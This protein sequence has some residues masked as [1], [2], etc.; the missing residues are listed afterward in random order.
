M[1]IDKNQLIV[2]HRGRVSRE[3]RYYAVR[4][5]QGENMPLVILVNNNSASATEIVAGAVQDHDRG[6][7]V[8]ERTFGKGLVQ[9]VEPLSENTGLALTVARYYTPSG[10]LIQRDYKS[11]SLYSYHYERKVPEH[12]TEV[13]LTDSGRLVTGG[14][15]ITPDITVREPEYTPFQKALLRA[16][17][18]YPFETSVGGFTLHYLGTRPTITK[19]FVVDDAVMTDFRKFLTTKNVHYSEP[20]L[21]EN[22]DWV[23]RKTKQ[24][25][26]LSVFGQPEGFKVQL[27]ADSQVLAGIEAVP[28]ARALYENARRI[29]AERAGAGS[30]RP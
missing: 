16:D 6:V 9:T 25:I 29:V 17:V 26:F 23:K 5:N 18:F 27:A 13:R 7:I 20:E 14:G 24:E 12:P 15:G 10:R 8:G 1:L 21:A 2:S 19:D 4:G 28:Q 22:L 11:I 30:Y 3:R